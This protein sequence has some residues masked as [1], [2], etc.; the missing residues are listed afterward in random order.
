MSSRRRS[1][2]TRDA[3]KKNST[4]R[5]SAKE[6]V[7]QVSKS[8][9][10]KF[11]V[12]IVI[13]IVSIAVGISLIPFFKGLLNGETRQQVVDGVRARGPVGALFIIGLNVLQVLVAVIPG[14]PVQIITGILY[15]TVGGYFVLMCGFLIAGPIAYVL[16]DRLGMPFVRSVVSQEMMDKLEFLNDNKR[17]DFIVFVL[18]FIPGLPKDVFTY[19]IPLTGMPLSRFLI[20]STIARTPA[21]IASTYTGSAFTEGNYMGMIIICVILG[22]LG[23]I[24]ILNRDRIFDWFRERKE[25]VKG[26]LAGGR[27]RAER[28]L[29]TGSE[30]PADAGMD[31]A[32]GKPTQTETTAAARAPDEAE[33]QAPPGEPMPVDDVMVSAA[34]ADV[35]SS[36]EDTAAGDQVDETSSRQ[37]AVR[38]DTPR[39][40]VQTEGAAQQKSHHE[41]HENSAHERATADRA[42]ARQSASR[43]HT[44][45]HARDA[46]GN[47]GDRRPHGQPSKPPL[48]HARFKERSRTG[49]S[50]RRTYTGGSSAGDIMKDTMRKAAKGAGDAVSSGAQKAWDSLRDATNGSGGRSRSYRRRGRRRGRR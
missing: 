11:A 13:I 15:G 10:I 16:V 49:G 37:D 8:N 29:G 19:L 22:A 38:E 14:E 50:R 41:D 27:T 24:G 26:L 44:S 25:D 33:P 45:S 31:A 21:A 39:E 2:K 17:I 34:G 20:L 47:R 42:H 43:P 46:R 7:E 18:Y 36:V 35:A 32:S 1:K 48:L 6:K 30:T 23:I 9:R 12:L 5:A 28:K 4:K 40:K 3:S